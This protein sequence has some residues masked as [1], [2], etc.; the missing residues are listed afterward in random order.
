[1]QE[2]RAESIRHA[3]GHVATQ[4][5]FTRWGICSPYDDQGTL[6]RDWLASGAHAGMSW[7]QRHLDA[8]L[9]PERVLP[10]VASIIMLSYPYTT[11]DARRQRGHIARYAQGEDYHLLLK[12]KLADLDETLQFY[13][14][15]QRC[16]TDS[17]PVSERF[18]AQR[19]G[20][21][22]IGKHGLLLHEREGSYSILASILTT[23]DLPRDTPARARCGSCRRCL[24]ACP[25]RALD[26]HSCDA[27]RCLSYWTIEAREDM[28]E[29]L[30]AA[31]QHE[32]LFGCDLCQ[33]ACPWNAPHRLARRPRPD[34][35][36]LMPA[37]LRDLSAQQ[38]LR[39]DSER[40]APLFYGSA[41]R[42]AGIARLQQ[43]LRA[44]PRCD[45]DN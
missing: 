16:F 42:R 18:F 10:D 5:G 1:M 44:L 32:R 13:G 38:L 30:H 22:W 21:G 37:R 11:Q 6:L 39:L 28:P 27:R 33:E 31:R 43:N 41:L 45:T 25:T 20:L 40:D 34:A 26:G 9:N 17:G 8:R 15:T 23:L 7:M 35:R 29:P 12:G 24:D 3:I 14:G 4:L 2:A 36:L 19:A